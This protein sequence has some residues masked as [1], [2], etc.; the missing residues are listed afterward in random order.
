MLHEA[1]AAHVFKVVGKH[2]NTLHPESLPSTRAGGTLQRLAV[3]V[4]IRDGDRQV[5]SGQINAGDII[6]SRD[7]AALSDGQ[8]ITLL[9]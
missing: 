3:N 8:T 4:G 7:V 5:I 1:G 9:P 2:E 6:V